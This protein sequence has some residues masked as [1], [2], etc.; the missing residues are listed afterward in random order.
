M[1]LIAYNAEEIVFERPQDDVVVPWYFGLRRDQT[2]LAGPK[3]KPLSGDHSWTFPAGALRIIGIRGG[4]TTFVPAKGSQWFLNPLIES[5]LEISL[6]SRSPG[7]DGDH[8]LDYDGYQRAIISRWNIV[9]LPDVDVVKPYLSGDFD[10]G[11]VFM[12]IGSPA[13]DVPPSAPTGESPPTPSPLSWQDLLRLGN[14]IS[15]WG[16]QA[17]EWFK[18]FFLLA[19]HKKD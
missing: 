2:F 8:E 17:I 6:H 19:F 7:E 9:E 15:E 16:P 5:S 1:T 11:L 12:S 18:D 3:I 4:G 14:L 10:M 13:V